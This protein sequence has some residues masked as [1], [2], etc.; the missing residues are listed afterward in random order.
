MQPYVH[1]LALAL[2]NAAAAE[3]TLTTEPKEEAPSPKAEVLTGPMVPLDGDSLLFGETQVHLFGINAPEMSAPLG[4][5]A[6]AHLDDLVS[7]QT[8]RCE[9]LEDKR[10]DRPVSLCLLPDGTD[11]AEAQL[12]AG[13]G[14]TNRK[15]THLSGADLELAARYDDAERQAQT[16]GLGLWSRAEHQN[17]GPFW[18]QWRFWE[19]MVTGTGALLGFLGA[20]LIKY[21]LDRRRD[22]QLRQQE[23]RDL[24]AELYAELMGIR[25]I[26]E[27]SVKL[28]QHLRHQWDTKEITN[29]DPGTLVGFDFPP[30]PIFDRNV[31]NLGKLGP[32]LSI[33]LV[34]FH[35]N[36]LI[37][38]RAV[39]LVRHSDRI[40]EG[41]PVDMLDAFAA[42]FGKAIRQLD[43]LAP[44]LAK[45]A[46]IA[47]EGGGDR[48]TSGAK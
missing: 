30:T 38:Q 10:Y 27:M 23:A 47:L 17:F 6:R 9:T 2:M 32:T 8:L 37:A 3:E 11:L 33:S 13:F 7:G 5:P 25:P 43:R 42:G 12:A 1:L 16:Q 29:L 26:M 41:V 18:E 31:G 48:A 46:G 15:F 39:D 14:T 34:D 28:A 35:Y 44:A 24:A 45:A 19:V 21:A 40:A 36:K 4:P 22:Q 20:T